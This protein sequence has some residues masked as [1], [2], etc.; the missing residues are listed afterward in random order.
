[1]VNTVSFF[2]FVKDRNTGK[3]CRITISGKHCVDGERGKDII[4]YFLI[5]ESLLYD[6]F[7]FTCQL[8]VDV[9]SI[10]FAICNTRKLKL[11][12]QV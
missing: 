4:G 2:T 3:L 8:E 6:V 11:K 1:M 9:D 10:R 7:V 12:P 5:A